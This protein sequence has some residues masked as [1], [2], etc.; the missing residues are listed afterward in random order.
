MFKFERLICL[1]AALGLLLMLPL[2][3]HAQETTG[4]LQ[5]TVKDP[6]GAV[7]PHATVAIA[8][9]S[10]VGGKE[11]DT[12]SSGYYR[13]A[14]LPPG[15]YTITVTAKGFKTF[16]RDGLVIDVGHLPIAD[17]ALEVGAESTVV[18]VSEV[19]PLI[20]TT[21]TTFARADQRSASYLQRAAGGVTWWRARPAPETR[22]RR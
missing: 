12:D 8:S 5:G 19:S 14:N 2:A 11:Q 4:G 13:F 6:S 10:L 18:E 22:C 7:V 21:I 3:G 20:E 1:V 17:V 15:S 9:A 16:K